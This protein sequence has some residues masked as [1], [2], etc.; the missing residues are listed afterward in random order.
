[1][2]LLVGG[3]LRLLLLAHGP[4]LLGR[5]RAY[6]HRAFCPRRGGN[7]TLAPRVA[8]GLLGVNGALISPHTLTCS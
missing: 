5:S 1:M 6:V 3:K 8:Y 2:V 4:E 7:V